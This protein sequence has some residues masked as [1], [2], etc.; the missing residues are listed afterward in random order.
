MP[1]LHAEPWV[2]SPGLHKTVS[3]TLALGRRWWEDHKFR[4]I[5]GYSEFRPDL[6]HKSPKN[7]AA[8]V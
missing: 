7:E 6:P 3:V 1:A 5:L 4:V 8:T 2:P